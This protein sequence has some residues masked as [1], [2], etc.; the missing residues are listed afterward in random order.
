MAR[1]ALG[2]LPT[3]LTRLAT[4]KVFIC[5]GRAAVALMGGLASNQVKRMLSSRIRVR[6]QVLLSF[7]TDTFPGPRRA[8]A[9]PH[10][11]GARGGGAAPSPSACET[12]NNSFTRKHFGAWATPY[13]SMSS[14]FV[15]AWGA[16][17]AAA[18]AA[19]LGCLSE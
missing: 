8:R 10:A 6:T 7:T 15:I 17:N 13:E 19:C 1:P 16:R 18:A 5:V 14:C 9:H 11:G 4:S 12:T 2:S 3:H